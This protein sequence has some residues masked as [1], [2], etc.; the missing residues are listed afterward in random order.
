MKRTPVKDH[1]M[2][3]GS[4][5]RSLEHMKTQNNGGIR[6]GCWKREH[7][8]KGSGEVSRGS[9][10]EFCRPCGVSVFVL[11]P[12]GS[13]EEPRSTMM[14]WWDFHFENPVLCPG[15]EL[16]GREQLD[17]GYQSGGWC[18]SPEK[19]FLWFGW[20]VLRYINLVQQ[21]MF[22]NIS[23]T[24]IQELIRAHSRWPPHLAQWENP[25]CVYTRVLFL[26]EY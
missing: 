2:C 15:G 6:R 12:V 10:R 19:V 16:T 4:V 26:T 20:I 24:V 11:R 18:N 5:S 8:G 23:F 1:S 9:Y 17:L 25:L 7:V 22:W 13:S 14:L 3:R 21:I